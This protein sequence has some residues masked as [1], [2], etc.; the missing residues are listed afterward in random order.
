MAEITLDWLF[1]RMASRG[2]GAYGLS[3]V[4]QRDHALQAAALADEGK[5][6][7][8]M[9]IAALFHDIGHMT[10]EA[11]VDLAS[12]GIDDK[13]EDKSADVLA[14]IFGEVVAEPVRLHVAAKR[15]LCSVES[16]YYDKLSEDSRISLALQGGLMSAAEI[17]AF[18][19]RP[20]YRQGVVLRQID[21]MAKQPGL[22]VPS[23][24]TFRARADALALLH[25]GD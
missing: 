10:S 17:K 18:E 12:A 7:K 8:A 21:D 5:L 14:P 23:L 15:Y 20:Y 1:E 2:D 19:T 6:G 9:V 11:D 3:A 16:D 24:E 4:T 13:H 22:A 25:Q